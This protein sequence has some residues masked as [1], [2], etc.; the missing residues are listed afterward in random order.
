MLP[1]GQVRKPDPAAIYCASLASALPQFLLNQKEEGQETQVPIVGDEVGAM[2]QLLC[3]LTR[4]KQILELGSGIGYSTHW[5]LLGWPQAQITSVDANPDRIEEARG[6]LTQSGGLPQVR[7]VAAWAETFLE[8]PGGPYDL[9]FLDA[10]KKDYPNLLDQ[11]YSLLGPGGLLVVDN[12]FY[13][14]KVLSPPELLSDKELAQAQGMDR[15]NRKV[16]AHPG[17]DSYFLPF[18]DGLLIARKLA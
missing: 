1:K 16:A 13:Q 17:L 9:I 10:T 6:Y 8:Q 18:G 4:P 14:G 5:M 15:F 3:S 12:V 7:L 2:L 11:C